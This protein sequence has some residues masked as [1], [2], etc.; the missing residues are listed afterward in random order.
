MNARFRLAAVLLVALLVPTSGALAQRAPQHH[1]PRAPV[2]PGTIAHPLNIA[3][4][5]PAPPGTCPPPTLAQ[6]KD[7]NYLVSACGQAN[8]TP[9]QTLLKPEYEA[10]WNSLPVPTDRPMFTFGKPTT[11]SN[12]KTGKF[13][14]APV[15]RPAPQR[16][17][18][19]VHGHLDFKQSNPNMQKAVNPSAQHP[20]TGVDPRT[21]VPHP[22]WEANGNAIESCEEYAYE[23]Y[24]DYSRWDTAV[25][26]C[27]RDLQ[28]DLDIA[29][30]GNANGPAPRIADRVVK[31]KDG[32]SL[33]QQYKAEV[34]PQKNVFFARGSRYIAQAVT[35]PGQAPPFMTFAQLKA[36]FPQFAADFDQLKAALDDGEVFYGTQRAPGVNEVYAN[37][38]AYHAGLRPKVKNVSE[39]EFEE[40]ARRRDEFEAFLELAE[41][42]ANPPPRAGAKFMLPG[43]LQMALGG[44]PFSRLNLWG[45]DVARNQR[46]TAF[47]AGSALA[48][49]LSTS[50]KGGVKQGGAVRFALPASL[51]GPPTSTVLAMPTNMT[52]RTIPGA[53][54]TPTTVTV[55]TPQ[56]TCPAPQLR[57][58][59][60][61]ARAGMQK[62]AVD[63][64]NAIEVAKHARCRLLNM[65]L[66]E[67]W[68]LKYQKANG[69]CNDRGSCGCLDL[70]SAACDWSPKMFWD[71]YA[72]TP[73]MSEQR[74]RD[75]GYCKKWSFA[76]FASIPA[77]KKANATALDQYL[78]DTESAIQAIVKKVPRPNPKSE[79]G[80]F[81]QTFGD[82]ATYGDEES[83]SA[84]YKADLGWTVKANSWC[85]PGGGAPKRPASLEGVARAGF[86]VK[87]TTPID[88]NLPDSIANLWRHAV[89]ADAWVR[90][91]E[92]RNHEL[93]YETH[94][95]IANQEIFTPIPEGYIKNGYKT[96]NPNDTQTFASI[97]LNHTF[98][99]PL[100]DA[101]IPL[102]DPALSLTVMA[103]PIPITGAVW[104]ELRYGADFTAKASTPTVP[105]TQAECAAGPK[106]YEASL[107]VVPW[108]ALDAAMTLGV[109][110]KGIAYAGI[111]GDLNL[112]TAKLPITARTWIS[113]GDN[114]TFD[115]Q[116]GTEAKML[117]ST[118]SGRLS[119]FVEFLVWSHE[120]EIFSWQ[121]LSTEIPLFNIVSEKLPLFSLSAFAAPP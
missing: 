113:L 14:G 59:D 13:Y 20:I 118:L 4:V 1:A 56:V 45:N 109:G 35:L 89:D 97:Q 27:G 30:L 93:R 95:V 52:S 115:L 77:A 31:A 2:H 110:I 64:A 6:C 60:D 18:H 105:P 76:G 66:A 47:M 37:G 12:L 41:V 15:G 54:T 69:G 70:S 55:D 44:D 17:T 34:P 72:K 80:T 102:P 78:K 117:L 83:F 79:P 73:M 103:G 111:R 3:V 91:N 9:C 10:Y 57:S 61:G 50:V 68:R 98:S 21:Y 25:K 58:Y 46:Q 84:G 90:V 29:Y 112:I 121:G 32:T 62:D 116:F 11:F 43:E 7:I 92:N 71:A 74:D 48:Q 26:Y 5:A 86:W 75:Y 40:F 119:A 19:S 39:N 65:T 24:Y 22:D 38:W 67:W 16:S 100:L 82:G 88:G 23:K 51:V 81:G 8:Q 36:Q 49:G 53:A 114:A 28:C 85:D 33:S 107:G 120:F 42:G 87:M 101:T 94:L 104:A 106:L 63:R 96:Y 99:K 108:A